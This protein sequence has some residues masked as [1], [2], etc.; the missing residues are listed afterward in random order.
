MIRRFGLRAALTLLVLIAIAPVFAVVVQASLFE[1]RGRLARA[2][3]GLRS[4]VD[5]AAARQESL[6]DGARQMLAAIAYSPPVFGDDAAACAAY[7]KKLQEHYPAA[8]GTFGLLDER[9]RLTCRAAAPPTNVDS[10]DRSFFRD[11]V[12]TGR[13]SVGEFTVSRASAKPVLPFG[14]PVYR[15]DGR[16]L[17]GVAYLALDAREAHQQLRELALSPETTL[18]VT[19]SAG[20]VLAAAGPRAVELGS[21]LP[22]AFLQRA[23]AQG[24]ARFE[25]ASG[26][27]GNEWAFAVQPVGRP[28]E[29]RLFVAGMASTAEIL[30]PSESRLLM[31]LA[32]LA[33]I[34]LL[35][36]AI[37]WA[38]GDRVLARPLLRLLHRVDALAHEEL[39]AGPRAPAPALRE[40]SQLDG[41]FEEVARRLAERAVQRDG[42]LAEM[43]HQRR[44]LE[45]VFE[46]MAEGVMVLDPQGRLLQMN[47]AAQ[48]ILGGL[49]PLASRKDYFTTPVEEYG[50]YLL[51]GVTPCPQ[52]ERPVRRALMGENVEHFRY[53]VRGPLS[54]GEEKVIQGSARPLA[55]NEGRP[56]G[57]V[58]VFFDVTESWRAE[59]ALR[60]SESRYRTLFESNPHPMWVFDRETMRFLT[61]N[62]AAVAH[63]GYSREEFLSMTIAD[64]RPREDVTALRKAVEELDPLSM[65]RGW[66]HRLKD[67]RLIWVEISSHM[68]E[69]DGR[70]ARMVLAHDITQLLEAQ[71]ALEESNESLEQRVE[72][73][74]RELAAANRELES[75]AYSVSHDLRAPLAAIDGFSQALAAGHEAQLDAKGRHFLERIR[76][77][78]RQMGDLI[79]D[80]LSLAR[81]TRTEI[82]AERVN[83]ANRARQVIE[84]LRQRDP[85]RDVSVEIDDDITCV[86]DARL[87]AIVLENLIENAWKFTSRTQAARIRVGLEDHGDGSQ[88]VYVADNGAGFDMRYADK[89]FNA[90]HRL[91]ASTDFEG[92]GIGLATVHRIVTRHGGR[93]WAESSPGRG[94]TFHF[95]LTPGPTHEKQQDSAGRGQ[96]GSPGTHPDDAGREQCPQ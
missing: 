23:I 43:A 90:F 4:V 7:M 30:A 33:F 8:Y 60:E 25:R 66:R 50:V 19:D 35:G 21:V 57:A 6:V 20:R 53:I 9:G 55:S 75:F 62:D 71:E 94:A 89:L 96:P 32:A 17:R 18:L 72:K 24:G 86:G 29:A 56:A 31:E 46:G 36:A 92:T 3:A 95:T 14:L 67:G 81:V 2:E 49:G 73:R 64:I 85:G 84:R 42:A 1:Q 48:A 37:A 76:Q 65:S 34:T 52:A 74:T 88:S 79:D 54:A 22:E 70:S 77:N 11:A 40:L 28:T 47:Q 78:T 61:V 13:F 12:A 27:D 51:D 38:L 82:K 87:V 68:L 10:S 59:Q 41:R 91:H 44:L 93:V 26:S 63:Y 45:S 16:S 83:V 69:Y 39:P 58:V 15:E 80:L 5:L